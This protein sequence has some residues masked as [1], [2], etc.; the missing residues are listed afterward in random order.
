MKMIST[1]VLV[2]AILA[3]LGCESEA[4]REEPVGSVASALE[5][6]CTVYYWDNMTC[7]V[8]DGPNGCHDWSCIDQNGM[9]TAD[10]WCP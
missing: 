10:G 7:T 6:V 3:C 5:I 9:I 8:C 4:P 2:A 1:A